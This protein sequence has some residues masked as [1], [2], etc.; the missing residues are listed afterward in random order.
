VFKNSKSIALALTLAGSLA[1]SGAHAAA[2]AAFD[3]YSNGGGALDSKSTQLSFTSNGI[4]V[5]ITPVSTSAGAKVAYRWDGIGV[6]TGGLDAPELN[7]SLLH[8]PGDALL[9]SFSQAV[10]LDK[11]ALSQWENGLFGALDKATITTGGQTYALSNSLNDNGL[12]V[13]T[14]ALGALIP[15]GQFFLLQATGDVSAFRLAGLNV[16]AVAAVP[17]ASTVAMF[18]LGLL[19]V[20]AMARRRTRG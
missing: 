5:T 10:T 9:L 7:S 15:A 16:T 20:A 3:F 2:S 14:F 4:G 6:Y 17:E 12:L 13:K 1:M 11:I 18:G 19:G 8:T